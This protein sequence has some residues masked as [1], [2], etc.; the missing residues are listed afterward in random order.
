MNELART[1]PVNVDLRKFAFDVR[2]QIQIPL[3]GK[4]RM[5]PALH[6]NLRA[7][8]RDRLLDFLVHLVDA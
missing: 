5:M 6:E 4:L 8:Q 1:E 2:E 3:H 7:A